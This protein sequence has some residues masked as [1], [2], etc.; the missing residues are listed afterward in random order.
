MAS[1]PVTRRLQVDPKVLDHARQKS[2]RPVWFDDAATAVGHPNEQDIESLR[3][4]VRELNI[5]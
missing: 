5:T 2:P 4:A 1:S 3:A